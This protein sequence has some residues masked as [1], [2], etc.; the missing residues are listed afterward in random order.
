MPETNLSESQRRMLSIL[1]YLEELDKLTR[2]AVF[3]ITEHGGLSIYQADAGGLPGIVL[4]R[5]DA[6]GE[7]WMEIERLRPA[8]PPLPPAD[9]APCA[10]FAMTRQSNRSAGRRASSGR[11]PKTWSDWKITPKSRPRW[12][13]TAQNSGR[14]G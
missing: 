9:L 8:R 4:G 3:E 11:S 6:E 12:I 5:V 2:R 7:I 14:H 1:E 10:F 13:D